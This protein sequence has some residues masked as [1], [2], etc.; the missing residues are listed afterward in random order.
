MMKKTE[1][2]TFRTNK[3]SKD[4]LAKIAAERKWSI[5]LLV[6]DIVSE[7]LEKRKKQEEED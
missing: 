5:S 4:E 6:E 1:Y 3:E 7:W 2:I